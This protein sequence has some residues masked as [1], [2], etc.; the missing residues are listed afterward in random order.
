[1]AK[2]GETQHQAMAKVLLLPLSGK[3]DARMTSELQLRGLD[4]K[5]SCYSNWG[6]VVTALYRRHQKSNLSSRPEAGHPFH[7][8][9]SPFKHRRTPYRGLAK[10]TVQLFMLFGLANL[11]LARRR[12][13]SHHAQGA[14]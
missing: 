4:S 1:M 12:L 2:T 11:V 7:V 10:N 14:S 13:P 3:E 9:K 8:L 5:A 6:D